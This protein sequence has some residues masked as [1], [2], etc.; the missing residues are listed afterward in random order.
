MTVTA[1]FADLAFRHP[2][3]DDHPA[4]VDAVDAWWGERSRAARPPRWWLGHA[5]STAWLAETAAGR[6]VGFVLGLRSPDHPSEG[7]LLEVAV[8]PGWRRHGLGRALVARFGAALAGAG[9]ERLVAEAWPG[10]P[11]AIRFLEA[12]GFEAVAGPGSQRLYGI[13]AWP[14]HDGPGEDRAILTRRL[15]LDLPRP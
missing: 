3:A 10:N 7:L 4:V 8:D 11:G 9:A 6:L 1:T 5:G 12:L 14:D 15:P 2:T 13:P